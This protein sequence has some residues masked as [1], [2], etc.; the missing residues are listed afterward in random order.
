MIK[1]L[2]LHRFKQFTALNLDLHPKG[3]SLLAGGNNSG[4]STLLH[5]LAVWEFCKTVLEMENGK[6]ML[7][8]GGK[9]G[10]GLGDDEFSPVPIPSLK[11]L[12][13]NLQTQRREEKDGYTLKI[14]C[15]WDGVGGEKYL[16][17]GLSLANDRLFVKPTASNLRVEDH[18]P[19][20]AFLP[21]FAGITDREAPMSQ[22]L[23]RR[24]IGQG[25][26]GAVLR[27][28]LLDLHGHNQQR[29]Q[30]L[31]GAKSKISDT[32]LA[33]L[34]RTDPWEQL[35]AVLRETFA[36]EL[37]VR[38]FNP[39]YHSYIKV[40]C[41]R[42]RRT[43]NRYTKVPHYAP[44]DLMVEGSGF[45][46][47]LSVYTLAVNASIDVI[48][49][50]EPDAHLH[51]SLQGA[52]LDKL[53][54]LA[55]K[56]GKQVLS[57]T[58]SAEILRSA[59]A[60]SILEMK[61][62]KPRYL[63]A[64]SQKVGVIAGLGSQYAP[65]LN[66]AQRT[67]RVLFVEGDVDGRLLQAWANVLGR[68]W[69]EDVV[70]W[71]WSAGHKERKQLFAQL[72]AE[73]EGLRAISLRDRDEDPPGTVAP[74]LRDKSLGQPRDG[75]LCLKWK[76]RHI[77]NYLLV[78]AAI[79]RACKRPLAE[80]DALL[81]EHGLSVRGGAGGQRVPQAVV[82]AR[83]KELLVDDLRSVERVLGVSREDVAAVME[84]REVPSD[85]IAVLDHLE[86]LCAADEWPPTAG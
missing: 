45:L 7:L 75:L 1:R 6:Q 55:G 74:D 38:L 59:P 72:R 80:V 28:L 44:R 5:S 27:N 60:S 50:D 63:V 16:E 25:L 68:E 78:P 54:E 82:D 14:G 81:A 33:E 32:D 51:P 34:R 47:W 26:A 15:T 4:K 21:P 30:E 73:V 36:T 39:L 19:R 84:A 56:N 18:V 71:P 83:G 40:E 61:G 70:L 2:T 23:R 20:V 69:P 77:E 86:A 62:A 64:E 49:L 85:V 29:R 10:L 79:A 46:Q 11:H 41:Y 24:L 53:R 67:R 57:A 31:R 43:G 22:A 66:R 12:W 13:T 52:L 65:R 37:D 8:P 35:A 76:R 58:H 3:V 42:V 48:L 9:K 17:L